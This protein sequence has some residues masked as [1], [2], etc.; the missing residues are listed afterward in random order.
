MTP[1]PNDH[2]VNGDRGQRKAATEQEVLAV[3]AAAV[4]AVLATCIPAAN[5]PPG[6][7]VLPGMMTPEFQ[8]DAATRTRLL[9]IVAD[10]NAMLGADSDP[11]AV[12]SWW[13]TPDSYLGG[14]APADLVED[15]GQRRALR[16]AAR[17]ELAPIF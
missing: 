14:K 7:I 10:I 13:I 16:M 8:F 4:A 15:V 9:P 5:V 1:H 17:R 2:C 3:Q 6:A 11:W 12:A